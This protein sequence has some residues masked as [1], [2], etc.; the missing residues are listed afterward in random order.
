MSGFGVAVVWGIPVIVLLALGYRRMAA[1]SRKV[2]ARACAAGIGAVIVLE[3]GWMAVAGALM[4]PPNVLMIGFGAALGLAGALVGA[5]YW[6][7][8]R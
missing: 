8:V 1:A 4:G 7:S 3:S 5:V 6:R 2:A